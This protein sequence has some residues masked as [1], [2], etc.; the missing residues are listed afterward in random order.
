MKESHK[1]K[2]VEALLEYFID[3]EKRHEYYQ[4]FKELSNM[5]EIISP[6]ASLRPFINDYETLA[7]IYKILK[8]AYDSNT[9]IDKE[10]AKK[11]A[12]LVQQHTKIA[13]IKATFDIYEINEDTLRKLEESKVS[14]TEKIFNLVKSIQEHIKKEASKS[15]YLISIGEKVE[16]IVE[17]YKQRQKNTQQ[18]L[19]ELKKLTED[20]NSAKKEQIEKNMSTEIFAIY[21][22]LKKE[23][24]TKAEEMAN[25]MQDVLENNP[26]WYKSDMQEKTFRQELYKVL[27]SSGEADTEKVFSVVSKIIDTFKRSVEK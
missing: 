20:I 9:P 26:Y 23:G 3:E 14:D 8:E 13:G 19:E 15:P 10:F 22:I 6:D 27:L 7:R 25:K 2:A 21:W 5:Y 12:Q 4:F 11:T 17:L 24:F 1:D 18:T 16:L